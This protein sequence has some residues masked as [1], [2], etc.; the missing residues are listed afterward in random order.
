MAGVEAEKKRATQSGCGCVGP[1][2]CVYVRV[3]VCMQVYGQVQVQFECLPSSPTSGAHKVEATTYTCQ[4]VCLLSLP[5]LWPPSL[6][7]APIPPPGRASCRWQRRCGRVAAPAQTAR[8]AFAGEEGEQI[9]LIVG[10]AFV[11]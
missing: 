11:R 7:L 5:P 1:W 10:D 9:S 4:P 8:R 6:P 3:W 2:V